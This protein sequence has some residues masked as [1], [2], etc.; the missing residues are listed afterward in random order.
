MKVFHK[1][2][3]TSWRRFFLLLLQTATSRTSAA[4]LVV[5]ERRAV[6]E[7]FLALSAAVVKRAVVHSRMLPQVRGVLELSVA[8]PA[9]TL[10]RGLPA[11]VPLQV[12]AAG[13]GARTGLAPVR[14]GGGVRVDVALVGAPVEEG[15]Q[16]IGAG[17][18]SWHPLPVPAPEVNAVGAKRLVGL[19]ASRAQVRFWPLF[20]RRRF[21][22]R[23]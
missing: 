5:R 1:R 7:L 6:L 10:A 20:A 18:G 2:N 23:G 22:F 21:G 19:A 13:E 17:V 8:D 4:F 11:L 12:L 3:D 16:A 9:S 15:L 14:L